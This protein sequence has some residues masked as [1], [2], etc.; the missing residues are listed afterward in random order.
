MGAFRTPIR[1]VIVGWLA[2]AWHQWI[3]WIAFPFGGGEGH[4]V[5]MRVRLLVGVVVV[6]SKVQLGWVGT[7][8]VAWWPAFLHL[9]WYLGAVALP[10]RFR[11]GVG[12]MWVGGGLL[13]AA[14]ARWR[15][16]GSAG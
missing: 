16:P 4:W 13:V 15:G 5:M 2:V 1:A 6:L 14:V 7:G 10:E 11:V 8:V 3:A 12:L 9:F